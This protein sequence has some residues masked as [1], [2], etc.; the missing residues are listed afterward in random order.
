MSTLLQ[1]HFTTHICVARAIANIV[2]VY[3]NSSLSIKWFVVLSMLQQL[4]FFKKNLTAAAHGGKEQIPPW[5]T[6]L[7]E[8]HA[9][10]WR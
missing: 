2:I 7:P 5:P 8:R 1:S 3:L 4:I 10:T 9:A 6:T